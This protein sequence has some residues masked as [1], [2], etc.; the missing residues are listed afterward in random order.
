MGLLDEFKNE[1]VRTGT[2]CRIQVI[3]EQLT[4]QEFTDLEQA[5]AD[6]QITAA[7]I[8]RVLARKNI[9]LQQNTITR[10]RRG[11]CTCAK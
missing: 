11:E 9:R 6:R 8:E 5:L 7:A 1:P 4:P 3:R 2:F 10:H